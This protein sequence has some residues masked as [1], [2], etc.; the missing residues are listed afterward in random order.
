MGSRSVLNED[1]HRILSDRYMRSGKVSAGRILQTFSDGSMCH[2]NVTDVISSIEE[3]YER[4]DKSQRD[5]QQ[6]KKE[7]PRKKRL[8]ELLLLVPCHVNLSSV[9]TTLRRS[10]R[11]P[12]HCLCCGT[13]PLPRV[14]ECVF[15][16]RVATLSNIKRPRALF[17][18]R[19]KVDNAS[20]LTPRMSNDSR[21]RNGR[22][23]KMKQ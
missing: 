6:V 9:T 15:P 1:L 16:W 20:L 18:T 23:H 4:Y 19:E 7:T 17:G 10:K 3:P 12:K 14:G 22:K 8:H 2:D 11:E 21:Q 13:H 5:G